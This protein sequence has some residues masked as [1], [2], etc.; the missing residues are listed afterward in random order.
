MD[1]GRYIAEVRDKKGFSLRELEKRAGVLNHVYIWRLERGERNAPSEAT[2]EKLTSALEM[3]QREWEV[4][5]L[6]LKTDIDDKLYELVVER[7]EI[8]IEDIEPVATMSF[9]GNKP[10]DKAG[11]WKLIEMIK[12]F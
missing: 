2:I 11:W 7:P 10:T 5:S 3:T 6:L 9:R 4:L 8:P 1:F 12:S